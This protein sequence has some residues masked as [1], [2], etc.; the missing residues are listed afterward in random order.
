M[1]PG[2][3]TLAGGTEAAG[4]WQ[5]RPTTS[6]LCFNDESAIG[7]VYGLKRLGY[8]IPDD[9]SVIGMGDNAFSEA[10]QPALTTVGF[11]ASAQAAAVVERLLLD[12][13][14]R[15]RFVVPM[16]LIHRESTGPAST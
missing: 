9:V 16:R 13:P 5:T 4:L 7:F 11:S 8:R 14:I 2:D 3:G 15:E 10:L 1:I 6:A 12:V